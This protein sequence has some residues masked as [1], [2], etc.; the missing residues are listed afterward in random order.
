MTEP[1]GESLYYAA[2]FIA[3]L[4]AFLATLNTLYNFSVGRPI[5]PVVAFGL[6]AIIWL[7]GLGFR[8]VFETREVNS[9]SARH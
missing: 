9:R 8:Y 1:W 2:A 7:I 4:I 3:G 6:A 5:I